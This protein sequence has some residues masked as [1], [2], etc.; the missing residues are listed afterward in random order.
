MNIRNITISLIAALSYL[1]SPILF[2]G[3]CVTIWNDSNDE[4]I[5]VRFF[6]ESDDDQ[7]DLSEEYYEYFDDDDYN[8]VS[9]IYIHDIEPG[10]EVHSPIPFANDRDV[11]I[12]IFASGK[13]KMSR[14]IKPAP[15]TN[16]LIVLYN[17][18]KN[19]QLAVTK[20]MHND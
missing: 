18:E 17:G 8:N 13:K 1:A 11:D 20:T 6:Q 7:E 19:F 16:F 10:R 9:A 4:K 3:D 15:N 2:A 12:T 5:S 14:T